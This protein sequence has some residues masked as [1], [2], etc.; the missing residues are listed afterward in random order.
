M[1]GKEAMKLVRRKSKTGSLVAAALLLAMAPGM[2]GV[3]A[4]SL[5]QQVAP[6]QG[7]YQDQLLELSRILGQ[8]HHLRGECVSGE[9]QLWRDNM[10]ELVRL[11]NP[12][13]SRKDDMVEDFNSAYARAR[14]RYPACN[15]T[16][17]RA[18]VERAAEG[19]F[20]SRAIA[21][22]VAR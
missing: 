2:Q 21:R 12:P 18:A 11:E 17:G 16:A 3:H 7:R 8:L 4:Q 15:K 9:R 22:N 13:T 1:A 5:D 19:E 10:M 6:D 20:L 14:T